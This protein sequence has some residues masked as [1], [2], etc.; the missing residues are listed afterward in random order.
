MLDYRLRFVDKAT[1]Q[2]ALLSFCHDDNAACQWVTTSHRW[3]LDPIGPLVVTLP[4]VDPATLAVV[5]PAVIDASYHV[6]IRLLA[7]DDALVAEIEA[8]G[9]VLTPTNP[10]RVWA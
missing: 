2:A 3:A 7:A 10:R 6:N 8:T 9:A 5:T 4:V 1:A